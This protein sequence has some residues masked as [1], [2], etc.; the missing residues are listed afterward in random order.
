MKK[1]DG[2]IEAV[3]Y[4]PEGQI[5]WARGYERRGATFSDRVL[6]SRNSLLERLKAGE[7]FAIGQRV[8]LKASTFETTLTVQVVQTSKGELLVAGNS[9]RDHDYL[10]GA[11]IL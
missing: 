8:P 4:S 1:L 6:I 11:P 10:E 9:Q 7:K 3:H 5:V 2:V